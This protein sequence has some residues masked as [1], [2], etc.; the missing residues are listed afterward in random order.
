MVTLSPMVRGM[1]EYDLD[2]AG[3]QCLL[4]RDLQKESY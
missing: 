3:A 4:R 1:V 2:A